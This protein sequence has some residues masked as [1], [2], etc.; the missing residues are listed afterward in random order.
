MAGHILKAAALPATAEKTD[1]EN[2]VDNA[3]IRSGV[4]TNAMVANAAGIPGSKLNLAVP[5]IIGG[6]TPSK[7]T[8]T[9][10]HLPEQSAPSTAASE[11]ALYTK[12]TSGQPELFAREESSGDEIQITGGGTLASAS[13][14]AGGVVQVVNVMDAITD[15][16][17]TDMPGD[18]TIPQKTEGDEYFSLAITPTSATNKLKI[19]VVFVFSASG[20]ANTS[21]AIFQDDTAGALAAVRH[22]PA[23]SDDIATVAF[24]HYM[25]SGTASAT[26]FKVRA[27]SG[28]TTQFNSGNAATQI[29][30][31]VCA[32]S[33]T[34]T[35]IKV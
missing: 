8:V 22:K 15:S 35:E 30:G 29:F 16:G 12:D 32:S 4:V 7:A 2:L 13:I 6:T 20:G 31:G 26:T 33:I 9:T 10:A 18:N 14:P 3:T 5:G 23:G 21:I 11:M 24:T 1:F 25:T 27:G 34:I 17:S 19:D 28:G